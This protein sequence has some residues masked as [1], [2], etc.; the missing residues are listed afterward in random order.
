MINEY[1]YGSG[2]HKHHILPKHMGGD[3]SDGNLTYLTVREH[4]IAH[5]LLWRIY[6]NVNDLRSMY[7]LGAKLTP[8]YR[9]RIG[10]FC[11]DNGIGIHGS[12]SA[13]K[14]EWGRRGLESQ[15]RSGS[16]DTFYWWSTEDGRRERARLGGL[17]SMR[18]GNNPKFQYW[19]SKEGQRKR[20]SL[21]GKSHK[22]K[23]CM[24]KPGDKSFKRVRPEDIDTFL[25]NGYIFGSP[26]NPRK[27]K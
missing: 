19:C 9:K 1:C 22:G 13:E 5:Y 4:V 23:K 6:K 20:A 21:G 8:L 12:T 17:A 24:Y 11:R 18:S 14:V 15:K 25:A 27:I 16:K 2:L 7:M 10:E 3:D 26:I